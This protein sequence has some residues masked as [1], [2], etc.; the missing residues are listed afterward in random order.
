MIRMRHVVLLVL[1]LM[2]VCLS[3]LA[4]GQPL[5]YFVPGDSI[6]MWS[7]D[8]SDFRSLALRV[9]PS[10][11]SD[12]VNVDKWSK[13][14][15]ARNVKY[16]NKW[17][18]Q[19]MDV[20]GGFP[21]M[22]VERESECVAKSVRVAAQLFQS[23][24]QA[25]YIDAAERMLMN[26]A[27]RSV[28]GDERGAGAQMMAKLLCDA[29]GWVYAVDSLNIYLNLFVNS[30]ARIT[31]GAHPVIIDQMTAV[32]HSNRVKIRVG[33]LS[34][35]KIPFTLR[36]RI[37]DWVVGRNGY[38]QR[39]SFVEKV[40]SDFCVYVNGREEELPVE[41]GYLVVQRK[42]NSGDEVFFDLP[43]PIHHLEQVL[44]KT[45]GEERIALQNGP[46]MY[47][48]S[49]QPENVFY[50]MSSAVRVQGNYTPWGNAIIK[51][52]GVKPM[53]S[54][55]EKYF[56][57]SGQHMTVGKQCKKAAP[58]Y[59]YPYVEGGTAVWLPVSATEK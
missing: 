28:M 10:L 31:M 45:E 7:P 21:T 5:V 2:S 19:E 25:S 16:W 36:I 55:S 24:P 48:A 26:Y 6:V 27:M 3:M 20:T 29:A 15:Y 49:Q 40:A 30:T 57:D 34:G 33:G 53:V 43:L 54:E 23:A 11:K 37:P 52:D 50:K 44:D 18:R 17:V 14:D 38:S 39:F 22:D 42:W 12:E 47:A 58:I 59:L 32:P 35:G 51:G 56:P 4:Q 1:S 9:N 13:R 46:W 8:G 41:N